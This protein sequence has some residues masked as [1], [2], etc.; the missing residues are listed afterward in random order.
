MNEDTSKFGSGPTVPMAPRAVRKFAAALG[1]APWGAPVGPVVLL[2][3]G[4]A[5]PRGLMGRVM[6]RPSFFF[7]FSSFVSSFFL[8]FSSFFFSFFLLFLSCSEESIDSSLEESAAG[9][10]AEAG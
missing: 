8:F 7:F 6:V 4:A 5:R 9:R 3:A 1:G 10:E 2:V